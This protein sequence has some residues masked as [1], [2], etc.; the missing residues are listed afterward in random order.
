MATTRSSR[1][2]RRNSKRAAE[3]HVFTNSGDWLSAADQ[4]EIPEPPS[5][6][7]D[8]HRPGE[9]AVRYH[10]LLVS[11]AAG[12]IEDDGFV[13]LSAHKIARGKHADARN[14]Q[15][16]RHDTAAVASGP[17]REMLRQHARLLVSRLD[18][19]ITD[20]AMLGAFAECEDIGRT[21][22]E[23]IVDDDAAIDGNA[24]I[25]R[26]RGI[27]SDSGRENP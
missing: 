5:N 17:A 6:T 4:F 26:Q 10:E 21:G 19:A 20:A 9:A 13:A 22:R 1:R 27:R 3:H 16:G 15:I 12:I 7:A 25:L 24:G 8:Q 2:L 23:M 14:L 18:Q 11:A